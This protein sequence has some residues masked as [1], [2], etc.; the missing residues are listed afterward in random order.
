MGKES[1]IVIFCMHKRKMTV[2]LEI[3]LY[4]TANDL[5]SALNEAYNLGIRGLFDLFVQ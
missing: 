4:I 3:P 1:A 2:D 5:V